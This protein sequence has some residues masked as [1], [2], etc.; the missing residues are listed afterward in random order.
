MA[1]FVPIICVL[2]YLEKTRQ[3]TEKLKIKA[4]EFLQTAS[5]DLLHHFFTVST[6]CSSSLN[7][8]FLFHEYNTIM[9]DGKQ[10][11]ILEDL[12]SYFSPTQAT[13]GS[14]SSNIAMDPPRYLERYMGKAV[15]GEQLPF[16]SQY[17]KEQVF[18]NLVSLLMW[19]QVCQWTVLTLSIGWLEHLG[20]KGVAVPETCKNAVGPPHNCHWPDI[21]IKLM[22]NSIRHWYTSHLSLSFLLLTLLEDEE[23]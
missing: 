2:Q 21:S 22:M 6:E 12:H 14:F 19:P 8:W 3:L 4:M 5:S 17:S 9:S 20:G 23:K 10:L 11:L 13:R 7:K 16:P 15:S 1:Q 18:F